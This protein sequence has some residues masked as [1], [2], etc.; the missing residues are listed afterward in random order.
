MVDIIWC[1]CQEEAACQGEHS[2]QVSPTTCW[3]PAVPGTNLMFAQL[4][5]SQGSP[6]R[7][8]NTGLFQG[9]PQGAR[10]WGIPSSSVQGRLCD[11]WKHFVKVSNVKHRKKKRH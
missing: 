2:L 6:V 9:P 10:K 8:G 4:G 5:C 7:Q 3:Q 1:P 11:T